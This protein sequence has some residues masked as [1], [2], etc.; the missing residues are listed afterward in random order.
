MRDEQTQGRLRGDYNRYN[1]M[2]ELIMFLSSFKCLKDE[3]SSY[4]TDM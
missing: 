3:I 1:G 2:V 4:P